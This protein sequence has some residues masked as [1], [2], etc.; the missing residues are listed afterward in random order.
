MSFSPWAMARAWSKA[1][2]AM[3]AL[4]DAGLAVCAHCGVSGGRIAADL[5]TGDVVCTTCGLVLEASSKCRGQD[6]TE[7]ADEFGRRPDAARASGRE[8]AV[9][10]GA[11][12]AARR[13]AAAA[14]LADAA[15]KAEAGSSAGSVDAVCARAV[16][17]AA[18]AQAQA[19][20][21]A[22]S[23]GARRSGVAPAVRSSCSAVRRIA[24]SLLVPGGV[25]DRA[26]ALRRA[27]G[28]LGVHAHGLIGA[29]ALRSCAEAA[30]VSVACV[31]HGFEVPAS[32]LFD[33]AEA[34]GRPVRAVAGSS[35][36]RGDQRCGT[37]ASAVRALREALGLATRGDAAPADDDASARAFVPA[38]AEAAACAAGLGPELAWCAR[39]VAHTVARLLP[40]MDRASTRALPS[41]SVGA[42]VQAVVALQGAGA[43]ASPLAPPAVAALR[44]CA[45]LQP[46]QATQP[47]PEL[48]RRVVDA[49]LPDETVQAAAH[50]ALRAGALDLLGV[51]VLSSRE[52]AAGA[53]AARAHK[54]PRSDAPG[55]EEREPSA[56]D[57]APGTRPPSRGST[58]ATSPVSPFY[59]ESPGSAALS[60]TWSSASPP[61]LDGWP[62]RS[63]GDAT[64]SAKRLRCHAE[65]L[66]QAPSGR[67]QRR[68][69]AQLAQQAAA[70][71][72]SRRGAQRRRRRRR[73]ATMGS[74][75]PLALGVGRAAHDDRSAS[76]SR[77]VKALRGRGDLRSLS[78]LSLCVVK[79]RAAGGAGGPPE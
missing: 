72:L 2:G 35:S 29:R 21:A 14:R 75:A 32:R 59:A 34:A 8:D 27:L 20:V 51:A 38:A 71:S 76:V 69:I 9:D 11:L 31:E 22:A 39:A 13:L 67:R 3:A 41:A 54:R 37:L 12:E 73:T 10:A 58:P 36:G 1:S 57:G 56:E 18:S 77:T 24:G 55:L 45:A 17:E 19:A 28:G 79:P 23:G 49:A 15:A 26:A 47:S 33:A 4:G 52:D 16:A 6:W 46:P 5:T 44:L 60:G 53:A 25:A 7:F 65:L 40:P 66:A 30:C 70:T 63:A 74:L 62:S 68:T 78:L 42:A 48:M 43:G 50:S 64:P 61:S